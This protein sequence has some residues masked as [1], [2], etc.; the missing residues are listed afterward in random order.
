MRFEAFD[1]DEGETKVYAFEISRKE[2]EAVKWTSQDQKLFEVFSRASISKKIL[3]LSIL[4]K[5]IEDVDSEA[6]LK[7]LN[8]KWK[9]I[10]DPGE[11]GRS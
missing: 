9:P 11:S 3:G 1:K 10:S 8:P 7:N 5:R 4:A 2:I 6:H